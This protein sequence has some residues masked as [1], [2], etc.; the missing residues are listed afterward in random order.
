M[1]LFSTLFYGFISYSLVS[2]YSPDLPQWIMTVGIIGI[3]ANS[4]SILTLIVSRIYKFSISRQAV[5]KHFRGEQTVSTSSA[6]A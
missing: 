1:A 4:L 6:R 3:V 5:V 2:L